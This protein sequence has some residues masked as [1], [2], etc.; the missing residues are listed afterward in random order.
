MR[1]SRRIS[2]NR[3]NSIAGRWRP[4]LWET[5]AEDAVANEGVADAPGAEG[6]REQISLWADDTPPALGRPTLLD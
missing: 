1:S 5:P 2:A 6:A 4:W 3:R